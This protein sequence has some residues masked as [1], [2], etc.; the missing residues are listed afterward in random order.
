VV[1][2]VIAI[3]AGGSGLLL[4]A[5]MGAL[6]ALLVVVFLGLAI[7][8]PLANVPENALKFVVGVLLSAFG[9]FW[10]GE[11]IGLRWPGADWS[12]LG[13]VAGFLAVALLAVPLCRAQAAERIHAIGG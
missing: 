5:S 13:L 3:G 9:C 6:A 4:P 2:I 10:V 11:G 1:F 7:H 8:R 12:I